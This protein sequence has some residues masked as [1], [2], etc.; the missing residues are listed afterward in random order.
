MN[1]LLISL[2]PLLVCPVFAQE[3]KGVYE[4][5]VG[6]VDPIPQIR[7][8]QQFGY[9][10]GPSGELAAEDAQRLYGAP[11]GLRSIRLTHGDADHGLIRLM[12][13]ERPVNDGLGLAPMKTVGNRW[14]ATLTEDVLNIMN[15]VETA[16]EEG[17]PLRV[18]PPQWATIY[19]SQKGGAAFNGPLHGVREML[20][21]QPLTRQVFFQRFNYR[22]P[23]Y[24][25]VD[26][27][28]HFS[29]SQV[30]HFGI[31]IQTDDLDAVKRFYGDTLG[32]LH[33]RDLEDTYERSKAG[34][35][36]FALEPGDVY[37]NTDFDDPRSS[38]SDFT[39]MRSG[40]LKIIRFP[41]SAKLPDK[42]GSSRPG[43]LGLSLYTYR[44]GD[45]AAYRAKLL[46]S[47]ATGVTAIVADEFGDKSFSFT[48]PDGYVWTLI[49]E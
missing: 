24:G 39:K 32:L 29:A 42:R 49:Q 4:A 33:I 35:A 25:T 22:I 10:V 28:S 26:P 8:W 40:R 11:S 13:W 41:E 6:V 30:T 14:T 45:I 44:V 2:A 19:A 9:R 31:L 48:A 17:L 15:H 5:C 38:K 47:A 18:V 21:L 46:A 37:Y 12:V 34:R 1:R 20:L 7:Y 23:N 27:A 36:V 16:R 3:I 43:C